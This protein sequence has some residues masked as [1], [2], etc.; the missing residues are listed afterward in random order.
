MPD[1]VEISLLLAVAIICMLSLRYLT[2]GPVMTQE[3]LLY[4]TVWA[5]QLAYLQPNMV[6]A[7]GIKQT[8]LTIC[9]TY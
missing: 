1:R 2:A 9:Q 4:V 6:Y 5:T 3:L 7:S 8:L